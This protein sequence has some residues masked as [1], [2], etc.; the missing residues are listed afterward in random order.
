[1]LFC[2]IDRLDFDIEKLL[3]FLEKNQNLGVEFRFDRFVTIDWDRLKAIKTRLSCPFLFTFRKEMNRDWILPL[4]ELEPTFCDIDVEMESIE[5]EKYPKVL[6]II[7]SHHWEPKK[8]DWEAFF[9]GM[10]RKGVFLYKLAIT[11][12]SATEAIKLLLWAKKHPTL[13]LICMGQEFAFARILAL[14]LGQFLHYAAFDEE[15]KMALGQWTLEELIFLYDFSSLPK[16]KIFALIGD[17]V[18]NSQGH[19]YHNRFFLEQKID[20]FYLKIPLK[21]EELSLFFLLAQ[22]MQFVGLSVTMPFKQKVLPF[23]DQIEGDFSYALNTL[24]F[25]EGRVIG[26]NTDGLGALDAIEKVLHVKEK[27][28]I[29]LGRGSTALSIAHEA[30]KRGAHLFFFHANASFAKEAALCLDCGWVDQ[31]LDYDLLI[32]ATSGMPIEPKTIEKGKFFFD[33]IYNQ[34]SL[35]SEEVKKRGGYLIEGS[36]MFENQAKR[37]QEFWM[38]KW[39]QHLSV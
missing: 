11:P 5:I 15:H 13:S 2:S 25:E 1:M 27:K 20:A 37:Q 29:V 28:V 26:I 16:K 14:H 6:F 9:L 32:Q 39:Q 31:I 21:E 7:S 33:V 22:K 34:K 19:R 38:Q 4:L 30:K 12:H 24:F 18:E 3:S 36:K 17:P 10:Q 8:I 35:F 23:V